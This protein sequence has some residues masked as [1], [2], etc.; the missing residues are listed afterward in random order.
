MMKR[1]AWMG[2]AL[3]LAGAIRVLQAAPLP[4]VQVERGG[5]YLEAGQRPFFWMGDT[6]W[7]LIHGTT[8]EECS[9][10]LATRAR[11]R[12]NVI[13][14][15]VL[16]ELD[17]IR[18]PSAL[19]LA[20]FRDEDPAKPNEA[21]FDRVVDIVDEAASLG[22][23]VGL[24]PAWGDKVD[25][26]WGAG[27]VLFNDDNL[28][29]ARAYARYLARKLHG[30][31]NVIWVLGGDRQPMSKGGDFRRVWRAMAAGIA[32]G[33]GKD[34]F[35]TYHPTAEPEGTSKALHAEPWLAMN[36]IQSGH[37]AG[38]DVPAWDYIARD[39]ALMPAKPTL[40]MEPNYEDHPVSPW[41]RWDPAKGYYRDH[42]VRKQVYRSVFAGGA[43]V[44]YGHHAIWPFVGER[45]AVVNH[46][47]RDWRDALTRPAATQMQFLRY[48][49]ESRPQFGRIPD[50]G[51]IRVNAD[52]RACH[53]RATRGDGYALVYFPCAGQM[54]EIDVAPIGAQRL[55]SWWY[56]PR[57]GVAQIGAESSGSEVLKIS[58]PAQGPDWVLVLDDAARRFVPPGLG[59]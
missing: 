13:Q 33:A 20:P 19:G 28:P 56:D 45:N 42:D 53:A 4:P 40:D 18:K 38:R 29:V 35:I 37:G 57:N 27:P 30:R 24:L 25:K 12:F 21:Y 6:A 46:A 59:K 26:A 52:S 31:T 55:R 34:A 17:G 54:L 47:D 23:Y 51:L 5:H 2:G 48:L 39:F 9:Y 1:S 22:L 11:Q 32:E 41:P 49:I 16:A 44:T 58:A 43:G 8:R 36:A 7:E 15:V 3:L 14:T 10:Y 50:Q